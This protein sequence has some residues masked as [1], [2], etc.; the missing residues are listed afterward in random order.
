[1]RVALV[2]DYLT[3]TGGAERV[4][5]ALHRL[6][7]D[8]P[9]Y[10]TVY[11]PEGTYPAFKSV[12]VR[13]TWLQR[14]PH[15]GSWARAL[16]PVY[17]LAVESLKLSG[18]DLVISSSS[19]WAHGTRVRGGAHLCYCYTPG[20]WLYQTD[21]YLRDAGHVPG[22]VR[23]LL[24]PLLGM[25]RRWDRIAASRPDAFCAMTE[26]LAERISATWGRSSVAVVPPPVDLDRIRPVPV[27]PAGPFFLVVSRLLAYKRVDLAIRACAEM[28]QRLVVVGAGPAW[29]A[30]HE[31]AA[32]L[33]ADVTFLS[34]A[35]DRT[36]NGLL[37]SCTALIQAGEEDFGLGPLEVNAAGRPAVVFGRGGALATTIDGVTGTVF[38]EPTVASLVSALEIAGEQQWDVTKLRSHASGFSEQAFASRL[39]EVLESFGVATPGREP[40]L[41]D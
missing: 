11:D 31:L 20:R 21:S 15:S 3:Q 38:P 19:G 4:V 18:Y 36:L 9:V 40:Q 16:L 33:G 10:T 14:L 17:P 23:P 26:Q 28:R 27:D 7:P 5:L 6:F 39:L 34:R 25:I 29:R 2:H 30:L 22:Y 1:M 8:A 41:Q 24:P 13:S 35:T 32:N 37:H 12:D